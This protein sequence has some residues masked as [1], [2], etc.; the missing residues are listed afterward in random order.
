MSRISWNIICVAGLALFFAMVAGCAT[1][2]KK[3]TILYQPV[4]NATGGS[5]EL[6]LAAAAGR[7][8]A[9][10]PGVVQWVIGKVKNSDGDPVGDIVTPMAPGDLFQDALNRE[11]T[12]AGYRVMRV[13]SLPGDVTRGLV[14]TMTNIN[15][16]EVSSIIKVEGSGRLSMS[17]ELWK[18]GK[19]FKKLYYESG[20]SD[21]AIK[22]RDLLLPDILQNALQSLMKQSVPE[23]IKELGK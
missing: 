23:I 8:E 14:V 9:G 15:L 21:F 12:N 20:F 1:T 6:Y 16:D 17:L 7:P 2:G 22:D 13:N 4:V 5:G 3:V 18:N 10:K 19:A 11:L